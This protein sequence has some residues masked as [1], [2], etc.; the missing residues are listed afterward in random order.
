MRV[1]PYR[2]ADRR[3]L[4]TLHRP[5][6]R[7]SRQLDA[8]GQG[9]VVSEGAAPIAYATLTPV[10]GLAGVVDLD[11]FVEPA[12]RRQGAGSKLL[13]HV[14]AAARERG[15]R[16][17]SHAVSTL[18]GEAAHFLLAR[19][20][21]LEHEEWRLERSALQQ[22]AALR[23]PDGVRLQRLGRLEA[24]RQFRALYERS[25]GG[26]PWY[27]PYT[28]DAEVGAELAQA[29][30]LLFLLCEGEAAGFAWTRL[31][32]G[33]VGEIEP[34]GIVPAFQGRGCGR[35]LLQAALHQLVRRGA[36]RVQLGVWRRN[37]AALAL[38]RGAG[39]RHTGTR[40]Y[41]ALDLA[42]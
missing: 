18:E 17:L 40:Y 32:Y 29:G 25:F 8:G 16:Q 5:A 20:F 2:P 10:P 26:T 31:A 39:F 7:L 35:V 11:C 33:T 34:L 12:R 6:R 19:G 3:A 24:I 13:Q 4:V 22:L 15:L 38:Y 37:Q 28:T 21:Y 9:W 1:R 23:L 30:D 41:L 27:Q 42:D 36:E 14:V